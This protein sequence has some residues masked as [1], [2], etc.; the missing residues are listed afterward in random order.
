[1]KKVLRTV[2]AS[3]MV[4]SVSFGALQNSQSLT[5]SAKGSGN[6]V[7]LGNVIRDNDR[8]PSRKTELVRLLSE[9]DSHD[10]SYSY[11][12]GR[13]NS[14]LIVSDR[15]EKII[16]VSLHDTPGQEEY[17]DQARYTLRNKDVAVIVVDSD[18]TGLTRQL[19]REIAIW[20][21]LVL[22]ER[23]EA[24]IL[25]VNNSRENTYLSEKY[26]EANGI[27]RENYYNVNLESQYGIVDLYNALAYTIDSLPEPTAPAPAQYETKKESFFS[28]L[29]SR[30]KRS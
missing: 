12:P 10:D 23:P 14:N 27:S 1:M 21:N 5:A 9:K 6:V 30:F 29:F 13:C 22:E 11:A 17:R 3:L 20:K 18:V 7:F 19:E 2:L 28:R 8:S 16:F 4:T 25:L 26:V 24:K 15:G